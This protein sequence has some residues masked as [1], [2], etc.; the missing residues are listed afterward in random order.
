MK[1]VFLDAATVGK[2]VSLDGLR[3][4]GETVFYDAT[5]Q[6]EAASRV[7]DCD[8]VITNKVKVYRDEI[9][10]ARNLKLICVAATGVNCVDVDY[11]ASKGIPVKNVPA[12]STESVAQ[13]C[14]MHILNMVGHG[15]YFNEICHDGRYSRSGM[16]SDVLNPFWELKGK[17]MGVIGMGNIGS[18]VAEL[19]TAF[20][21]EVSY[22]STSGT[23]HC[24]T[25]PCV[26]L[27]ELLGGSDVVSVNC[28]LNPKTKDL[29]TYAELGRMKPGT[30]I[31]NCSRGGIINEN[32]LVRALNDGLIAGAAVDTFETEPLP[33]DHPYIAGVKDPSR[34]ILSPHIGWTSIEARIRLVEVLEENIRTFLESGK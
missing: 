26:S 21:M 27:E 19:A 9:D 18:R 12:Y 32:D 8:I 16:F 33:I 28:P 20:G 15:M 11:A 24:R 1:I 6:G 5:K 17:K 13:V 25:Y 22:Y 34:L 14:F 4:F 31:V 7:A 2:D 10:A 3:Q 30:Y 23:G 29:I